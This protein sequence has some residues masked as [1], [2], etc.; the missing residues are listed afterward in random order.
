MMLYKKTCPI[1]NYRSS[2]VACVMVIIISII[3]IFASNDDRI[4]FV[5]RVIIIMATF[6]LI[7]NIIS[8][9]EKFYIKDKVIYRKFLF[10]RFNKIKLGAIDGI[11]ITN[12][13]F[14]TRLGNTG[15][16]FRLGNKNKDGVFV[17][18]PYVNLIYNVTSLDGLRRGITSQSILY[19]SGF[20]VKYGFVYCNECFIDL[21]KNADKQRIFIMND[22]YNPYIE[23]IER[24]LRYNYVVNDKNCDYIE[25]ELKFPC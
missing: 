10:F 24:E 22:L 4:S 25:Y 8:S 21:L 16:R 23:E 11:L 9:I 2:F 7:I 13:V 18:Y 19:L 20:D 15:I 12:A 3:I 5:L 1:L 14:T 17:N 6:V